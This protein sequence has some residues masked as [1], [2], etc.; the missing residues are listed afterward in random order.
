[1]PSGRLVG[2]LDLVWPCLAAA[3][4]EWMWCVCVAQQISSSMSALLCE[5]SVPFP[6]TLKLFCST[7]RGVLGVQK[8]SPIILSSSVKASKLRVGRGP[9]SFANFI[10]ITVRENTTKNGP[11]VSSSTSCSGRY[12]YTRLTPCA[13]FPFPVQWSLPVGLTTTAGWGSPHLEPKWLLKTETSAGV[14]V[15]TVPTLHIS[16]ECVKD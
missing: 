6:W 1:M 7:G 8:A 2:G 15:R 4:M 5:L 16:S 13:H 9:W 12:R 11:W 10:S 3:P 14:P